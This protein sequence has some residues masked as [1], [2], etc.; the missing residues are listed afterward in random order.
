MTTLQ[1][2]PVVEFAV[3]HH[4]EVVGEAGDLR[5]M[6]ENDSDGDVPRLVEFADKFKHLEL[7]A[8]VEERDGFVKEEEDARLLDKYYGQLPLA[9]GEFI[10]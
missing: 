8:Q 3:L 6:V 9:A 1:G 2:A 10:E 4:D 5:E 7:V